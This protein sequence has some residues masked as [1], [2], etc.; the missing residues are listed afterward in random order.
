MWPFSG[1]MIECFLFTNSPSHQSADRR[2]ESFAFAF[3]L[4]SALQWLARTNVRLVACFSFVPCLSWSVAVTSYSVQ[5]LLQN[6]N[7]FFFNNAAISSDCVAWSGRIVSVELEGMRQEVAVARFE[8]PFL[9]WLRKNKYQ[10]P[11]IR[12]GYFP[13][14]SP[15]L[16][17]LFCG[18]TFSFSV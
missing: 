4:L 5:D 17:E 8:V 18:S 7:C 12:T 11:D 3:C 16:S 14:T 1:L 6:T 13:N 2:V 9:K 15:N 10:I